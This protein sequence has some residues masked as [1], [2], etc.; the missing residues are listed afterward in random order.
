M[1]MR[2]YYAA[3]VLAAAV[4]IR[5]AAGEDQSQFGWSLGYPN[6]GIVGVKKTRDEHRRDLERKIENL[7]REVRKREREQQENK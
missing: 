5:E 2:E 7:E 1:S 6:D 3:L 4:R